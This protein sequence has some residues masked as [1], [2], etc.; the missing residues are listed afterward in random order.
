MEYTAHDLSTHFR[1][2]LKSQSYSSSTVRNYL[3]DVNKYL[4]HLARDKEALSL[5]QIFSTEFLSD[6]LSTLQDEKYHLRSL[7]SLNKFSQFAL[8][9]KYI[10]QNPIKQYRR[11]LQSPSTDLQQSL[12]LFKQYLI[13]KNRT[14]STIKNYLNDLQQY[15]SWLSTT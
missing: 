10:E 11:S 7:S 2:W 12:D 13:K 4:D 15:I 1:D 3:V 14:P 9:Q 8:S 5:K 6:Y